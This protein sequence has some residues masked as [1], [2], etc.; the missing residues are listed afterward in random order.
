MKRIT[1]LFLT[2]LLLLSLIA[3]GAKGAWQEQYDLGM[4][5]LNEGNYQ[6]A[7][8][9]FEAAIEIDPKR[10]EAYLGAAEAYMGLGDY[11]S[12][13]KILED[14]LAN[15]EN[16]EI[17]KKLDDLDTQHPAAA[18]GYNPTPFTER[19]NYQEFSS[20][21]DAQQSLLRA[22]MAAALLNDGTTTVDA[23][24][25][26]FPDEVAV[27]TELDS[28]RMRVTQYDRDEG[29]SRHREIEFEMRPENGMGY[30]YS[31]S[32]D[33]FDTGDWWGHDVMVVSG[34]CLCASWLW[35]GEYHRYSTLVQ[36]HSDLEL[37][38]EYWL[39]GMIEGGF[40]VGAFHYKSVLMA[41]HWDEESITE[42]TDTYKKGTDSIF[43]WSTDWQSILHDEGNRS[44]ADRLYW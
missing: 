29:T 27:Y 21:T 13:R 1:T 37:T 2:G 44:I 32:V 15:T 38:G 18:V 26:E 20:L 33:D 11:V 19:E 24:W 14:G 3:C 35:N 8:I 30:L 5:Y 25:T 10:P 6:E 7:V 34:S 22:L 43:D 23:S 31:M 39:D 42:R 40:R 4:R 36:H 12:A 16:T 9:A 17:R 41:E 28:Y